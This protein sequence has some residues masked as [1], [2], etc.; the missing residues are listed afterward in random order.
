MSIKYRAL[1]WCILSFFIIGTAYLQFSKA[2]NV[3]SNILKLIPKTE[4]DP[5][6][7]LA[8]E[9]FA[10][11]NMQYLL[12]LVKN[13]QKKSAIESARQLSVELETNPGIK[14]IVSQINQ[15]EENDLGRFNYDY[16]YQL[17]AKS[18]QKFLEN[19]DY[20]KF[21][22]YVIEQ[23]YSPFPGGLTSL[24]ETDPFLLSYRF[25]VIN[26]NDS[27]PGFK[28]EDGF[29]VTNTAGNYYV[30][31]SA[32]LNG[33]P[34][35]PKI[36]QQVSETIINVE[37]R[38]YNQSSG[39]KL[40]RTGAMFYAEHA[41]DT[42]RGEVSTIGI[43]SI[44]LIISLLL[45]TFF[46]IRPILMVV[47]A[48]GYGMF[49]GFVLVHTIFGGIHLL[50]IVFGASLIGVAV[51]YAFHYLVSDGIGAGKLKTVFPA[52]TLGLLSSIIGY[53]ALLTTPFPGLQQMAIFCISGLVAAYLTVVLLYPS[54]KLNNNIPINILN[55]CQLFLIFGKST[56]AKVL[57]RAALI[58]PLVALIIASNYNQDNDIRS[59]QPENVYLSN[60]EEIL[61]N[62]LKMPASNQ[63]Y[64]VTSSNQQSL[65]RKL[66]ETSKSLDKLVQEGIIDGYKS[67]SQWLPSIERQKKNIALYQNLYASPSLEK[68]ISFGLVDVDTSS[69]LNDEVETANNNYLTVNKW[70]DSPY[71]KR[72]SHL[73]LGN[74]NGSYATIIALEGINE[75]QQLL[76]IDENSIFIDKVSKVS[77]LFA[78]YQ[79]YTWQL[80]LIAVALIFLVLIFR[81]NF[82]KAMLLISS[83]V[84]AISIAV[85]GIALLGEQI[86]LF[87]TLALFLVLGIGIDYGLFFAEAGKARAETLLAVV[88]SALTTIF[89]FGLLAM[90]ET[91]AIHAFGLT[92]LLGIGSVFFL[93]PIIGNLVVEKGRLNYE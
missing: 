21:S 40:I 78:V 20:D 56:I 88:L 89:S 71:G 39:S 87:N 91:S 32:K 34:F 33:S 69:R 14:N 63:F 54:I 57:W 50:T 13:E 79:A 30:L 9:K 22:D 53:L 23:L 45:L 61:K 15:Q 51:D 8:F 82:L 38:W 27:Y 83:P 47:L 48:V 43:G 5:F 58:L 10:N 12:F 77:E 42:A 81:Y 31:V 67:I 26:T 59:L 93:S 65:L 75:L 3:E 85:L 11:R 1:V 73:W 24:I 2:V 74:V 25:S 46:S 37:K 18:D 7:E 16:R 76:S 49:T 80:L 52:I 4:S 68:L 35:D 86:N 64:L 66:E 6:V 60:Q 29:L 41:F 28:L 55:L 84:I 17:M 36:Q 92:M 72:S 90:S 19:A 62:I 70:L 44:L